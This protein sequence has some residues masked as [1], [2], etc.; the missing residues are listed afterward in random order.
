M[1]TVRAR[2]R[3]AFGGACLLLACPAII[4]LAPS[5]DAA[6]RRQGSGGH[7]RDRPHHVVMTRGHHGP[8]GIVPVRGRP[9]RAAVYRPRAHAAAAYAFPA[10][11]TG[12]V[13]TFLV[14]VAH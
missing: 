12:A 2:L 14:D 9:T 6:G 7:R 8:R 10:G 5:A 11:Y 1:G 13:S 3:R 4:G